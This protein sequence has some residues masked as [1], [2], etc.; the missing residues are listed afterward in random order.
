MNVE[1]SCLLQQIFD[2]VNS[3]LHFAEAKN[4]ALVAFNVALLAAIMSS[5]LLDV[6]TCFSSGIIIALLI[7]TMFALLSFKPINNKLEKT[8][9]EDISENLLHFAYISSLE[10]EEYIKKLYENY[11]GEVNIDIRVVPKIEQDYC[12][13]IIENSRIA[14]RKQRY[15]KKGFYVVLMTMVAMVV[16][17]I[18]A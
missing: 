14:M 6:F 9:N 8:S 5:N 10:K 11:W 13:E 18:C 7:S 17:V 16:L 12:S 15:F 2:N 3:W 4:A 1:R